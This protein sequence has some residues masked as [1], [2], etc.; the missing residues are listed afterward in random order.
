MKLIEIFVVVLVASFCSI[1]ATETCYPL[2]IEV[3]K[4][5][6]YSLTTLSP[7]DQSEVSLTL[8]QYKPLIDINC[9]QGL[10]SFLCKAHAPAC[11]STSG[12]IPTCHAECLTAKSG[13]EPIMK[14]FSFTWPA[15]LNCDEFI[16]DSANPACVKVKG[17]E[18]CYPVEVDMCKNHG[19]ALTTLKPSEQTEADSTLQQFKPLI[20]ANCHKDFGAVLCKAFV[21]SCDPISHKKIPA[22][23][24]ECS[25]TKAGCEPI[26]KSFGFTWPAELN[27]DEL[28]GDTAN[29]ACTKM[30]VSAACYPLD[31]DMCKSHGYS[32][33][34]LKPSEQ[35]EAGLTLQS[36]IPLIKI[37]CSPDLAAFLCKAYAP[38]CDANYF[39]KIP[40]CHANCLNAKAGC[41]PTMKSFS[42]RWPTELNCDE[43]IDDPAN[44]ACAK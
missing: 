20:A 27:C 18:T 1:Q 3:C 24:D 25:N 28:I 32:L 43:F 44:T 40:A 37:N 7:R 38:A 6:G 2:E 21:P 12:K 34:T 39:K 29:Q 13:C 23:H 15:A 16:A 10:S 8:Q 9:Y 5:L 33:T 14:K 17:S 30:K 41:E 22:C 35:L 36:F 31:I 26:M 42:F 11:D 4:N 19:Y